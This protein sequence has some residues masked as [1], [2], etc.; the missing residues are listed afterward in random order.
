MKVEG[1]PTTL[2]DSVEAAFFIGSLG[3][4]EKGAN[5]APSP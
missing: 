1:R 5:A 4:N 2:T 3:A